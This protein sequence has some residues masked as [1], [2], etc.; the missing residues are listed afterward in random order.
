MSFA[1]LLGSSHL[2]HLYFTTTDLDKE[3]M[4]FDVHL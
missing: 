3:L 2:I 4:Y 1:S